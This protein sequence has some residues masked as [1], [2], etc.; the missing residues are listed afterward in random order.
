[1]FAIKGGAPYGFCPGKV[2]WDTEAKEVFQLL[3]ISAETGQLLTDGGIIN[4]PDWFIQLLAWFLPKYDNFKF[5]SKAYSILGGD[6]KKTNTA[7]K[8]LGRMRK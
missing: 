1:M 5:S 6:T 4:Q 2:T 8:L 3:I 7:K